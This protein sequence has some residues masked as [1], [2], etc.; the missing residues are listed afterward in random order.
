MFG[1]GPCIIIIRII[2]GH[3]CLAQSYIIRVAY[4]IIYSSGLGLRQNI[5]GF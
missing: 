3:K 1:V 4:I 5:L 2:V